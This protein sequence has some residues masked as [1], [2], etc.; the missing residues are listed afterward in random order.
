MM[1]LL[2]VKGQLYN[3]QTLGPLLLKEGE[4]FWIFSVSSREWSNPM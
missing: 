4:L 3:G 2:Q 1:R